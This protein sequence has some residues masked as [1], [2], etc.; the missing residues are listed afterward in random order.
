MK[1]EYSGWADLVI[2]AGGGLHG[3][4]WD[5]LGGYT[6]GQVAQNYGT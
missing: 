5:A 3:P 2:G 6:L 4:G 1:L